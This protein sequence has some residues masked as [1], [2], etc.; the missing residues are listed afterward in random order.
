M[1]RFSVFTIIT[2]LLI[3][4]IGCEKHVELNVPINIKTTKSSYAHN[5]NVVIEVTNLSDSIAGYYICS[6]Y[7]GIPPLIEN[8]KNNSWT[9]YWSPLCDGFIS[10]CCGE[11][12]PNALY[13]DTLKIDFNR[14]YYRVE[15][16]LIVKPSHEYVSYYSN[17][18]Q[19]K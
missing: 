8:L 17:K 9:A 2:F 3:L 12:Q 4:L 14:G 11:L 15:Y 18:F 16:Q 6:S 10:H 5:E 19:I 1:K 7:K 13:R